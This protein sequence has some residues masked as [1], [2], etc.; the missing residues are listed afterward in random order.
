MVR[1]S[2][3]PIYVHRTRTGQSS[4]DKDLDPF[5][6][7]AG[8]TCLVSRSL[9]LTFV[10]ALCHASI[11]GIAT[12]KMYGGRKKVFCG[13]EC[14]CKGDMAV[15]F[16][17]F[18]HH[19][20][21]IRLCC[22]HC[23]QD[24]D[25]YLTE[26]SKSV[27]RVHPVA[28]G[29]KP[30]GKGWSTEDLGRTMWSLFMNQTRN[31]HILAS[32]QNKKKKVGDRTWRG[33][34]DLIWN[35]VREAYAE[36]EKE[37]IER[38]KKRGYWMMML[39]FAWAHVTHA[40]Q[41]NVV[42]SDVE[43]KLP[44]VIIPVAKA[45][46]LRDKLGNDRVIFPATKDFEGTSKSME[47]FGT[48]LGL[49]RL[50]KGGLLAICKGRV[51]DADGQLEKAM[52]MFEDTK[53]IP[54]FLDPGHTKR[55]F[56]KSLAKIFT[57]KVRFHLLARRMGNF[58]LRC[59]YEA[60]AKFP[61]RKVDGNLDASAAVAEFL[62]TWCYFVP[63]YT[64][65]ECVAQCPCQR[66]SQ[67]TN[68]N[69]TSSTSWDKADD[70]GGAAAEL[71][72]GDEGDHKKDDEAKSEKDTTEGTAEDNTEDRNAV[73]IGGKVYSKLF[74]DPVDD[75]DIIVELR[76]LAADVA[77]DASSIVSGLGTQ[78]VESLN[79]ARCA[80]T[81]KRIEYPKSWTARCLLV[82][83]RL[84]TGWDYFRVVAGKLGA[85]L[86]DEQIVQLTEHSVKREKHL[87]AKSTT[88]KKK[89]KAD[90]KK[91][92]FGRAQL[93]KKWVKENNLWEYI[94]GDDSGWRA[95]TDRA[96]ML[97]VGAGFVE[98]KTKKQRKRKAPASPS[99]V[100]ASETSD[101]KSTTVEEEA[102]PPLKEGQWWCPL[103]K[104]NPI[105]QRNK[106]A[107]ER[108]QKHQGLLPKVNH[109]SAASLK[110]LDTNAMLALAQALVEVTN[111]ATPHSSEEISLD[112]EEGSTGPVPPFVPHPAADTAREL[113][114]TFA[115]IQ[116]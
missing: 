29:A 76:R 75:A 115:A 107:H 81:S 116:I 91:A 50:R 36:Q 3:V 48:L 12:S 64:K 20:G 67:Q 1:D 51:S 101:G 79:A 49:D 111:E 14:K 54:R 66:A 53:D 9:I 37:M 17:N 40:S 106:A 30:K 21:K 62:H 109:Y 98:E 55:N 96:A 32:I 69:T 97:K 114:P 70:E 13:Q 77:C 7:P 39:D 78:N 63:H 18:S 46:H 42:I 65:G 83:L 85:D 38:I 16:T 68:T 87:R 25:V 60:I 44:V 5:D 47:A 28:Y 4:Y 35:A 82:Y 33:C 61:P 74:I 110:L 56:V 95:V 23:R 84:H 103:C 31:A 104:G 10:L 94:G 15:K 58:Y 6:E 34:S 93:A 57:T 71:P 105:Q 112:D 22:K 113:L 26:G 19:G 80:D 72:G 59:I 92:A 73:K 41:G 90:N 45:R 52:A 100:T 88:E 8:S 27:Q 99:K 108:S 102:M 89:A 2:D 43:T 86:D 24:V 11:M